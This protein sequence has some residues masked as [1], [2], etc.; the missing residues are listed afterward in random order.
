MQTTNRSTEAKAVKAL[1]TESL[2]IAESFAVGACSIDDVDTASKI[3]SDL[4]D[5]IPT[6]ETLNRLADLL[7]EIADAVSRHG[8]DEH[9]AHTTETLLEL[10]SENLG[11]KYAKHVGRS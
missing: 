7:N 11:A 6:P 5:N 9:E 1:R 3:L 4:A 8:D 10:V 2:A